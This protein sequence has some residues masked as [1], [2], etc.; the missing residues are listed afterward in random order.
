MKKII[1][2]LVAVLG[3]TLTSCS[4]SVEPKIIG[5]GQLHFNE[6]VGLYCVSFDSVNYPIETVIYKEGSGK[7]EIVEPFEGMV[8]TIFKAENKEG[9]QAIA[10]NKTKKEIEDAFSGD[11]L[12]IVFLAIFLFLFFG[13]IILDAKMSTKL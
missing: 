13:W 8:V 2:M 11:C 10:G 9:L 6:N 4:D 7:R 12:G 1:F 5:I 3:M